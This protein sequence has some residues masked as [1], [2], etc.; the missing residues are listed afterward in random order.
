MTKDKIK[1]PPQ[2]LEAERSVLG[3]ILI[4]KNAILKIVDTLESTDFYHP[5]HQQI[6]ECAVELFQ[7]LVG[8]G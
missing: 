1:V 6:Y 4:D 7:P 5:H 2:D 8:N 3:S